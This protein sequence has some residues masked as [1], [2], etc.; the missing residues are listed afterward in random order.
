MTHNINTQVLISRHNELLIAAR[1]ELENCHFLE[2]S[3]KK[4]LRLYITH[5][6]IELNVFKA[7]EISR[8]L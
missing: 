3:R 7:L 4:Q 5:C 6:E 1:K 8:Y 2:F